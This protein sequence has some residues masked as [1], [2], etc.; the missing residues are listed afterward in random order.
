M[1]FSDRFT[2]YYMNNIVLPYSCV[3]IAPMQSHISIIFTVELGL[4]LKSALSCLNISPLPLPNLCIK[5]SNPE[6]E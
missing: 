2:L 5:N 6:S 3:V 4:H 1:L